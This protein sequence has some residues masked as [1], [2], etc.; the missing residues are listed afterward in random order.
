MK[1]FLAHGAGPASARL[2][3]WS[4]QID[5]IAG[6]TNCPSSSFAHD[7]SFCLHSPIW[8]TSIWPTSIWPTSIWHRRGRQETGLVAYRQLTRPLYAHRAAHP[9]SR[10]TAL[11]PSKEHVQI[12]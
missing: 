7:E 5:T 9:F 3:N 6:P 10:G 1:S 2:T 4:D 12:R 8:P 11:I